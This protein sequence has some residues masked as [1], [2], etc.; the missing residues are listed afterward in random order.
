MALWGTERERK[1]REKP[2]AR[3][4]AVQTA[5]QKCDRKQGIWTPVSLWTD[6]KAG[7]ASGGNT[8]GEERCVHCSYFTLSFLFESLEP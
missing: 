3:A 8:P 1:Q 4:N 5:T 2:A 6:R 7:A